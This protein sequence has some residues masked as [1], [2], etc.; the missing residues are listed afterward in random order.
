MKQSWQNTLAALSR[1]EFSAALKGIRRGIEKEALRVDTAARLAQTPHPAPLGAALTHRYITTDYAEAQMEFI[2]P[3]GTEA[4]ATLGILADIHRFVYRHLGAELLWPL[5]M[6]CTVEAEDEIELAQYGPSN[7]GTMKTIYRQGLKNRYGSLMQ[8]LTGVHYNFS[9]P[10][11]FW[12]V[13]QKIKG[14]H[15]PLQDFISESYLGLARNFF[16][17]GWLVPYLFGASPAVGSSFLQ[18]THSKLRLEPLGQDTCYLP[19]ATSLRMSELGYNTKVQE[20]LSVSYNSLAEFV[21]ELRQAASQPDAAFDQIGVKQQ[22]AY[23]QLNTNTLQLENE[24]YAPIRVKRVTRA[25]ERIS[26]ALQ[27]RGVEYIEVRSLDID[28][29][30]ATGIGLEQMHFLDIF[31]TYCLLKDSPG[32]SQHQQRTTRQ[33]LSKVAT[34]GR[35]LTLQLLD[36]TTP[37]SLGRW[38]EEIF[39]DLAE[40]ARLL[41]NAN[42]GE[43]FQAA[44]NCQQQ[45]LLNPERTPS[46]RMLR[47]MHEQGLEINELGLN[48]A[49]KH[50]RTLLGAGYQQIQP[51]EFTSEV[52]ASRLKQRE[53]E[54]ADT[55][56]F[57]DFLHFTLNGPPAAPFPPT[58]PV[59]LGQHLCDP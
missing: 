8:V 45:K 38:G 57:D 6:P 59:R 4:K 44:L 12:P 5:S 2:T 51:A 21:A 19:K 14:E 55:L 40:V 11:G 16:R 53:L 36:N 18:N 35:D 24:L 9:L 41:D 32:L 7:V 50:R 58:L 42:R 22:G 43:S 34:C 17:L 27:A 31:L 29:Y 52:V 26:D 15:Q 37:K 48:L 23:R 39:A 49:R 20:N 46:A 1:P 3:A 54:E 10:E 25:N 47:D 33:N 28:P 56:G 30:V 13:W